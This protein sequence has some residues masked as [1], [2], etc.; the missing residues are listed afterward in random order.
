M[1]LHG[2]TK[3]VYKVLD[4][5]RDFALSINKKCVGT[6]DLLVGL[7][8][9][10]SAVAARLLDKAGVKIAIL[11]ETVTT[12]YKLGKDLQGDYTPSAKRILKNSSRLAVS[13]GDSY[14]G[15][16][17]ILLAILEDGENIACD[18]LKDTFK[19]DVASYKAAIREGIKEG[20]SA[21]K[22]KGANKSAGNNVGAGGGVL[23]ETFDGVLS[24]SIQMEIDPDEE[25]KKRFGTLGSVKLPELNMETYGI[26]LTKMAFRGEL[27]PVIGRED[28]IERVIQ[29]LSRKSKNNPV[30]VGESGVGKS[31]IVEGLA[32]NIV[33]GK[34]PSSLKGK[35]VFSLD[36]S[37]L[38]AGTRYRGDFE[39]RL[40]E[41]IEQIQTSGNIILFI[42]EIHTIVKSS[43]MKGEQDASDILKPLLSRGKLQTIGAT[44]LDEYRTYIEKDGALERRFQPVFVEP[45]SVE[46]TITILFGLKDTYEAFHKVQITDEAIVAAAQLSD[47]YITDRYLPDKAID[48]IDEAASRQK[49]SANVEPLKLKEKR[50]ELETLKAEK[51]EA[52]RRESYTQLTKFQTKIEALEA[53]VTSLHTE[54]LTQNKFGS[55]KITAEDIALI[56]TQKTGIPLGR[57]K[58]NEK[59]R[60]LGL[61]DALTRR[62]IGQPDA[63]SAVSRAIKRARAGLKDPKRPVGSFIFLGPS[64]VGK[65]ELA[66]SLADV[67]F[68]G[69]HNIVRIDMSEYAEKHAASKLIGSPPGYVGYEDGGFLTE[70]IR[71]KPHSLILLDEIE[72]AHVDIFDL[73][74]QILDDGHLTDSQGV[75]V[76]FKNTIIIMTSNIGVSGLSYADSYNIGF[77]TEKEQEQK[78][79]ELKHEDL[80]Q[81]KQ[82][83]YL[84]QALKAHF[85]PEFLN[86]IDEVVIFNYLTKTD[87]ASIAGIMV[88]KLLNKLQSK[89]INL[90]FKEAAV[91]QIISTG[92]SKEY[93]A[94]PLRKNLERFIE[95]P[96]AELILKGGVKEGRAISVDYIGGKFIF[97]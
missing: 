26:D 66:K 90:S 17:H 3:S 41:I 57:I 8:E 40:K 11:K 84:M 43:G 79:Q 91:H 72:K 59:A 70:Q 62:V 82:K 22:S 24:A 31:A 2:W 14:T 61:E 18:I 71:R 60:L 97:G 85:K 96:L 10:K 12:N 5:A 27:D 50:R 67:F 88:T 21:E 39:E 23:G 47:R 92:Y 7:R 65:T 75:Q 34:V 54:W 64:G 42:D 48:L 9:N 52:L 83:D 53:Q 6:E 51:S 86:R 68:A 78:E 28:E 80:Q 49:I 56:I 81:A 4:L 19:I 35:I 89:G 36:V 73:L 33:N 95:D 29:I 74:L 38:V 13:F 1:Q 37:K 30:L 25:Y 44:T 76:D 32:Q 93:G 58:E 46:Q 16:E 94:R 15:T 55:P 87:I 77:E 63:I 20:I 45:P 69:Q